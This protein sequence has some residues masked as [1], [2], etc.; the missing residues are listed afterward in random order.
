MT[1]PPILF[2]RWG[3]WIN[4]IDIWFKFVL[5]SFPRILPLDEFFYVAKSYQMLQNRKTVHFETE[6]QNFCGSKKSDKQKVEVKTS[7][8][9]LLSL[10]TLCVRSITNHE[11]WPNFEATFFPSKTLTINALSIRCVDRNSRPSTPISR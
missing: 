4:D 2:T 11:A 9:I 6:H 5:I 3:L 7:L 10:W 1:L 8:S